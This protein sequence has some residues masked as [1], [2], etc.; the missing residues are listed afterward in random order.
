MRHQELLLAAVIKQAH[1]DF[2]PH[3]K[4]SG[5]CSCVE[6]AVCSVSVPC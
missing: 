1:D 6:V 4:I 2:F 5:G 3:G